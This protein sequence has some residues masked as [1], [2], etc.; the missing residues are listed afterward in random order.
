MNINNEN[1]WS[2]YHKNNEK[3]L[4]ERIYKE[5]QQK[6]KKNNSNDLFTPIK[7][8]FALAVLLFFYWLITSA[9]PTIYDFVIEHWFY[10]FIIAL[11]PFVL[12]FALLKLKHFTL[13]KII[14][15]LNGSQNREQANPQQVNKEDQDN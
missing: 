5:E 10:A 9:I 14:N 6:N 3:E 11:S 15:M 8:A 4:N 1:W 2:K 13:T 12:T 7:G